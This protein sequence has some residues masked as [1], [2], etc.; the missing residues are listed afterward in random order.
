MIPSRHVQLEIRFGI[1]F[2]DKTQSVQKDGT[3]IIVRLVV[4]HNSVEPHCFEDELYS[5]F[6]LSVLPNV[7]R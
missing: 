1:A 6:Q 2:T 7:P 5:G 4:C 3:S